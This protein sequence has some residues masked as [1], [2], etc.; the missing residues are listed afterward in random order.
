MKPTP[1]HLEI[2]NHI[3]NSLSRNI[4]EEENVKARSI[5]LVAC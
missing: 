5:F 1:V 3:I 4:S 2:I